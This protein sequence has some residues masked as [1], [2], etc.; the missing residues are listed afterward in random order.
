[1]AI[2]IIIK[3]FSKYILFI[4]EYEIN[5]IHFVCSP[6]VHQKMKNCILI[7]SLELITLFLC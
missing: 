5:S 7:I 4:Y 6:K 2:K 1:M 3:L